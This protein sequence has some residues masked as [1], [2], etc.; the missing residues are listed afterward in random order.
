MLMS[1]VVYAALFLCPAVALLRP[2]RLSAL[3]RVA[4]SR[5]ACRVCRRWRRGAMKI[6]ERKNSMM[7]KA[8]LITNETADAIAA[9]L[10][11]TERLIFRLAIETGFRISDILNLKADVKQTITI[12]ERKTKKFRSVRISDELYQD[13]LKYSP[14]YYPDRYLFKS[15][16]S[17]YKPYSRMTYHRRLKQAA[18]ALQIDFSAH[19]MRKLYALNIFA[20]TGSIEAV[21]EAMNHKYITTTAT[22]LGIDINALLLSAINQK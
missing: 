13:L 11:P 8:K 4:A 3:A 17:L 15:V 7:N 19:S 16:R 2:V 14:L 20:R 12:V 9:K 21:K 18:K 6:A 22:Y 5:P 1:S 10:A